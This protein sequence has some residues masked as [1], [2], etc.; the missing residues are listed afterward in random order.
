M[1]LAERLLRR[2]AVMYQRSPD[3]FTAGPVPPEPGKLCS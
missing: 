2:R 3:R 1:A